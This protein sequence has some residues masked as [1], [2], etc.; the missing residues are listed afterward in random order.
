MS[1]QD[2]CLVFGTAATHMG[3]RVTSVTQDTMRA[4]SAAALLQIIEF[5]MDPKE[6]ILVATMGTGMNF[7]PIDLYRRGLVKD[8]VIFG[9]EARVSGD[10]RDEHRMFSLI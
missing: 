7:V 2:Y 3:R 5:G 1:F 6:T 8:I 9:S 10:L 4:M